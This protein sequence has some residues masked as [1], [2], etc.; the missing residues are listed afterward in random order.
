MIKRRVLIAE[1]ESAVAR[2]LSK[3]LVSEGFSVV[4]VANGKLALQ[5][6]QEEPFPVL[7]T[8]L[9]MPEIDGLKE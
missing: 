2:Y 9:N 7:I 5:E 4:A 1:D 8:D 3:I 6:F